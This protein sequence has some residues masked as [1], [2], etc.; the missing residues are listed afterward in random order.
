MKGLIIKR[1]WIDLILDGVK[2]W[3]IRGSNTNVRGEIALIESG[4]KT[5]VGV[6][7]LVGS[8]PLALEEYLAS[9]AFHCIRSQGDLPYPKT[10]AWVLTSPRRLAQPVPYAHPQGAVIWVNH[11]NLQGG[12]T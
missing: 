6:A 10:Y 3:E 5:V 12:G 7:E 11:V 8:R 2:G 9:E 4:T 1:P